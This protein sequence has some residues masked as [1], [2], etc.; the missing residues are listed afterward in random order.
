MPET[1]HSRVRASWGEAD[2]YWDISFTDAQRSFAGVEDHDDARRSISVHV[3]ALTG[4]ARLNAG[5]MPGSLPDRE[6]NQLFD[7]FQDAIDAALIEAMG[8]TSPEYAAFTGRTLGDRDRRNDALKTLDAE[9][10]QHVADSM[11]DEEEEVA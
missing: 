1:D 2:G 8:P 11:D 9:V 6:E 4:E 5:Y 10:D 3:D 7:A